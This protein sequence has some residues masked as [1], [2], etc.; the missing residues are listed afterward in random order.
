MTLNRLLYGG[1]RL[2]PPHPQTHAT[3]ALCV[4]LLPFV[5]ALV[6]PLSTSMASLANSSPRAPTAAILSMPLVAPPADPAGALRRPR[7]R[8]RLSSTSPAVPWSQ[9]RPSTHLP[10][11]GRCAKYLAPSSSRD[12][13]S[14][15]AL[16]PPH[17]PLIP[18]LGRLPRHCLRHHPMSTQSTPRNHRKN[19]RS[20]LPR[21]AARNPHRHSVSIFLL[22]RTHVILRCGRHPCGLLAKVPWPTRMMDAPPPRREYTSPPGQAQHSVHLAAHE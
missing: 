19:R 14:T 17:P 5:A 4:A 13:N 20:T 22:K 1:R 16:P 18:L 7:G 11:S 21:P 15:L 12:S 8:R 9:L 2:Y 3:Q 6:V 10:R